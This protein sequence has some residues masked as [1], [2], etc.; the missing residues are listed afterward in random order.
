MRTAAVM[1]STAQEGRHTNMGKESIRIRPIRGTD[2]PALNAIRISEGVVKNIYSIPTETLKTTARYF[3]EAGEGVYC[4]VAE[5]Q[6][7]AK[8]AGYIRIAIDSDPRKRHIGKLSLAV[9]PQAQGCG[10]GSM[11]MDSAIT[12]ASNWLGLTKLIL[13]VIAANERAIRLYISR[14]FEVEGTLKKD[15]LVDGVLQDALVMA[16]FL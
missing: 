11:L 3:L 2:I 14:G 4:L 12:L 5:D 9:A 1:I 8:T 7:S 16:K 15:I 6:T 13:H 10:V